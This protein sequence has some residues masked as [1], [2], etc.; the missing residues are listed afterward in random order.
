M[1]QAVGHARGTA[2]RDRK[3]D[4]ARALDGSAVGVRPQLGRRKAVGM[5]RPAVDQMAGPIAAFGMR[6]KIGGD[7]D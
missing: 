3:N 7:V 5:A 1:S 6:A 2:R 4:S